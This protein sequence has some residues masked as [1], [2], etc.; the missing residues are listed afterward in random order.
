MSV[1]HKIHPFTEVSGENMIIV[2]CWLSDCVTASILF[3]FWLM[4]NFSHSTLLPILC[5]QLIPSSHISFYSVEEPG[6]DVLSNHTPGPHCALLSCRDLM[7]HLF[8]SNYRMLRTEPFNTTT[9]FF[10][11][12]FC[13]SSNHQATA[14]CFSGK[15]LVLISLFMEND[16][17]VKSEEDHLVTFI[18]Y[19]Q[20]WNGVTSISFF[21]IVLSSIFFF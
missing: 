18:P 7:L 2:V 21:G 10:F 20:L 19:Y 8:W 13:K 14:S 3:F 12:F 1:C 15:R 5:R 4:H 11:F 6:C 16:P 9:Q 17:H